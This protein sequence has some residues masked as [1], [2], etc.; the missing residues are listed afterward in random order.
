MSDVLVGAAVVHAL[1]VLVFQIERLSAEVHFL[2]PLAGAAETF[3]G[4][5]GKGEKT[6][7]RCGAILYQTNGKGIVA[8]RGEVVVGSKG[9]FLALVTFW[10]ETDIDGRLR[11]GLQVAPMVDGSN[12][13]FDESAG[14]ALGSFQ[15]IALWGLFDVEWLSQDAFTELKHF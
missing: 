10:V 11:S 2:K 14:K 3:V 5:A 12:G 15:E 7:R 8:R 6:G 9:Y 1:S 13:S 4:L